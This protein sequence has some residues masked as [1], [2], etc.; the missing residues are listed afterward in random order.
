M[1]DNPSSPSSTTGRSCLSLQLPALR[2]CNSAVATACLA[3]ITLALAVVADA[4][5]DAWS[6][7]VAWSLLALMQ[8][9][10][11]LILLAPVE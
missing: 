3:R 8:A 11:R 5:I 1:D 10:R 2:V 9:D 4:K 6:S 7:R